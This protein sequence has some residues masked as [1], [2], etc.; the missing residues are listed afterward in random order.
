MRDSMEI[1][2]LTV[3][4]LSL[5]VDLTLGE[6]PNF[7]HPVVWMGKIISKIK[8]SFLSK[9][10]LKNQFIGFTMTLFLIFIFS[11]IFYIILMISTINPIV[12]ILFTSLLLSTTFA[13]KSLFTSVNTV[14]KSLNDDLK[15]A[16]ESLSLL[17]SRNTSELS[18]SQVVSA[19]IETL[20]ENVTDSVIA[21]LFFI[22]I[23]IVLGCLIN[24]IYSQSFYPYFNIIASYQFPLILGLIAGVSYR[25]VNTLDAMV[26][27]K[28]PKNIDIGRF[29]A[30]LDDYLNYIPARITGILMV[31]ASVIIHSNYKHAWSVMLNDAHNTPSPNSGYPMAA[32]AGAL[33]VQLIKPGVYQLGEPNSDLTLEKITEAIKLSIITIILFLTLSLLILILFFTFLPT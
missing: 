5:F 32:A 22:F 23:A 24:Q 19:A 9:S 14:K 11:S 31:A 18:N 12:F 25:V 33:D 3:I 8:N 27:Y 29:P 30:R 1:E 17:V 6:L 26:G 13:I 16:R 15:K 4:L 2:I 7:I 28:D 20:T 21:P 10:K